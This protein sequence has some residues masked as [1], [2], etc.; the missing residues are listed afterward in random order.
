MTTA[1]DHDRFER[2][3]TRITVYC[4]V[5]HAQESGDYVVDDAT[6]KAQRLEFARHRLRG[7][8]WRCDDT[9]DYCPRH[10]TEPDFVVY[11]DYGEED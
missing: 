8:G 1:G 4:D 2:Y 5:C 10:A 11:A 9:G 3:T 6:T 7:L